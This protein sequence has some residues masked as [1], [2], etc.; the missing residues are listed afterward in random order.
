MT[1]NYATEAGEIADAM[2]AVYENKQVNKKDNIDGDFSS[3][4]AS[5]PTV[6]AVKGKLDGKLDKTHTSHKGKN[7]VTD[8]NGDITF[9]D[10][11]TIPDVS[12]KID[13][14]GTG[15]SKS[16]TTLNHSNSV[17]AQT[18]AA[19]K[20]IKFDAQGHIT[21]VANVAASD[22]PSH[23]HDYAASSHSHGASEVTDANANNYSN[24]GSLSSGATQQAINAA[25]N[26]KLGDLL[27]V[28]F[29][30]ITSN[31]GT[32]SASTM[33]K[34]YV[35]VGSTKTDVYY[36]KE[37]SGSYS[38]QKLDS[39]ILDDVTIPTDVSDLTDNSNTQFTP[40]SHT[41]GNISNDGKVGTTSGKPLITGT[42][43]AVTAGAFGSSSGQFAEGNHTHS[44]YQ[45]S[46]DVQSEI[47]AFASALA[48][49]INPST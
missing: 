1:N 22:L 44:N 30:E 32:A 26:T 46:S 48:A 12:G 43:G 31:K 18:T 37:S 35:E 34:L 33:N 17:N 20:K 38:W 9:E 3:D 5:Y 6:K 16:G 15:L 11:P 13:T 36:T 19:L 2:N 10:K 29:I 47:S 40:K 4:S 14:A 42:G 25:I 27:N 24:M 45:T 23:T 41:H 21:D 7:V 28:K 49:A 39:N 8:S